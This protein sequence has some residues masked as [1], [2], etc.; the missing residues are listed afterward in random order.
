MWVD[1]AAAAHNISETQN[2]ADHLTHKRIAFPTMLSCCGIRLIR[3]YKGYP[4]QSNVWQVT[5]EMTHENS[6][7]LAGQNS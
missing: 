2:H 4:T 3:A 1:S 5:I 6:T 7:R